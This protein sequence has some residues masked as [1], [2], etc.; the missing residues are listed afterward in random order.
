VIV[1]VTNLVMTDY[2]LPSRQLIISESSSETEYEDS[3]ILNLD[4]HN[5]LLPSLLKKT[6][7]SNKRKIIQKDIEIPRKILNHSR[8]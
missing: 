5:Y 2:H 3:E 8:Q 1:R 4:Y 6:Q 7:C